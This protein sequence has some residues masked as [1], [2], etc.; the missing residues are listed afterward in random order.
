VSILRDAQTWPYDRDFNLARSLRDLLAWAPTEG[1]IGPSGRRSRVTRRSKLSSH[2]LYAP[3]VDDLK[4]AEASRSR[5]SRSY[6][7]DAVI[8]ALATVTTEA[9][10]AS[11]YP[12]RDEVRSAV[13]AAR[14]PA[15]VRAEIE[16]TQRTG[17]GRRPTA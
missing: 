3:G 11:R 6:N 5:R 10:N 2:R 8:R 9:E 17:L 13:I 4:I 14:R 12:H 16:G 1:R 7:D 15:A